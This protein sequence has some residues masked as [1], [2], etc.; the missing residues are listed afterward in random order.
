LTARQRRPGLECPGLLP[1]N[2]PKILEKIYEKKRKILLTF[3]SVYGTMNELVQ[4]L[5]L[6]RCL[7]STAMM[8]EIAA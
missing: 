2:H 3:F 8:R 1:G 4:E 7:R 5:P 6:L